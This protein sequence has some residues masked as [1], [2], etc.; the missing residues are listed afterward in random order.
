MPHKKSK[1]MKPV[2]NNGNCDSPLQFKVKQDIENEKK[3]KPK[4]VFDGYKNTSG[5][6][7]NKKY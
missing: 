2:I 7:K 3:I 1:L 4:D 6:V 5:K